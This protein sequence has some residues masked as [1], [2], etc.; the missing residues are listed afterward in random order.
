MLESGEPVRKCLKLYKRYISC[1]GSPIQEEEQTQVSEQRGEG[2]PRL[3]PDLSE[4]PPRL[5]ASTSTAAAALPV[6][7]AGAGACGSAQ[8]AN[9]PARMEDVVHSMEEFLRWAEELQEEMGPGYVHLDQ[10]PSAAA[11][12]YSEAKAQQ[13]QQAGGGQQQRQQGS[14]EPAPPLA[15]LGGL[16][17][18]RRRGDTPGGAQP[19]PLDPATW[20]E[21]EKD[22]TEV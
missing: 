3:E 8:A 12:P 14:A 9:G 10:V 21:F 20:R 16:L 6:P 18:G 11:R 19:K 2:A 13:G 15:W 5:A 22:F 4:L 17:F 1:A 7:A